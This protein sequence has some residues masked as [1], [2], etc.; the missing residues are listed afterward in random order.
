MARSSP[1]Y[2]PEGALVEVTVRTLHSLFLLRP[3]PTLND[4]VLGVLARAQER[5]A[6]EIHAFCVLS[7]HLHLLLSPGTQRDLSAFMQFVNSNLARKVGR[8]HQWR[9]RFWASRYQAIVVSEEDE[10]QL[11]RLRY[12]LEQG[13]KEGLVDSPE[14]WPGAHCVHALLD[15]QPRLYG[16]WHD[17]TTEYL[18]RKKGR[19]IKPR[20][21]RRSHVLF[22]TPLPAL[23][24]L[25][26]EQHIQF[27]RTTVEDIREQTRSRH[28]E[29]GT[30]PLGVKAI[31]SQDPHSSPFR[32]KRGPAP[33]VHAATKKA[34]RAFYDALYE[35]RRAYRAAADRLRQGLPATFPRD[36]FPP[37][38]PC[39]AAPRGRPPDLVL[40]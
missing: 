2:L 22:L 30:R 20:R 21:Y 40:A 31:L 25:S 14:H 37:P 38:P 10:A 1:R 18:D 15:G 5:F 27:I 28:R 7:N 29:N 23:R 35:F 39:T 3:S 11:A 33:R 12:M 24:H 8:L 19:K 26:K 17:A 6:V 16:T 13:V 4:I 34:R 9:E 36:C 32:T